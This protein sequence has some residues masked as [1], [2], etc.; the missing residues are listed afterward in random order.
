MFAERH[1]VHLRAGAFADPD[2]LDASRIVAS[3]LAAERAR[4]RRRLVWRQVVVIGVAGSFIELTLLTLPVHLMAG[5]GAL[6]A[7]AAAAAVD[8]WWASRRLQ[9]LL[10]ARSL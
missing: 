7:I 5:L 1:V 2:G 10:K 3:Y 6:A 8:E 4:E 9:A